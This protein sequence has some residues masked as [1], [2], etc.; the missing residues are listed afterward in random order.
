[1]VDNKIDLNSQE[2]NM[3][4]SVNFPLLFK[5]IKN[6][7]DKPCGTGQENSQTAA[8]DAYKEIV[9]T[10]YRPSQPIICPDHPVVSPW[11]S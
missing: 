4:S 1:V 8:R 10:I 11:K 6:Y 7:L 5:R 3:K 2:G 9:N